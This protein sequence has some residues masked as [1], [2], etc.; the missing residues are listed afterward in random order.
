V[1]LY[2]PFGVDD[3]LERVMRPNPWY[4]NAPRDCYN[5]KAERWRTL[6]PDLKVEPFP[7]TDRERDASLGAGSPSS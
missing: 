5:T 3:V 1:D 7:G 2:A 6:W 4:P